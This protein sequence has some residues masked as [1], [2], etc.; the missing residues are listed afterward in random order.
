MPWVDRGSIL[1]PTGPAGP[2]GPAGPGITFRGQ[3]AAVADLPAGAAVGDAY[4]VQASDALFVWDGSSWVDGGSIQGPQGIPGPQGAVG[5]EG[6]AGAAIYRGNAW[7]SGSGPPVTI[8]GA[9]A[10]DFYLDTATNQ[11]YRLDG[12]IPAPTPIVVGGIRFRGQVATV[13]DLPGAAEALQGDAYIVQA[14]DSFRAWDSHSSS[15]VSGGSI[16]G[17]PGPGGATGPPGPPG[18]PGAPG[19]VIAALGEL[20]DVAAAAAVDRS[21]LYFDAAAA[22]FRADSSVTQSTLTDGGNF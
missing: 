17:P 20:P 12:Q 1:G 2:V 7:W 9:I 19:P 11:V 13:A 5:P 6:L 14:D 8:E 15:W 10:G 3:L 21:L 16:A 4:L 22:L 18:P